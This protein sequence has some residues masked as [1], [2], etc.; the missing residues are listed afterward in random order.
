MPDAEGS[1]EV[2]TKLSSANGAPTGYSRKRKRFLNSELCGW[3]GTLYELI[4]RQRGEQCLDLSQ[5]FAIAMLSYEK[6]GEQENSGK[7]RPH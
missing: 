4:G 6:E 7:S 5:A 3:G 1:F 2:V